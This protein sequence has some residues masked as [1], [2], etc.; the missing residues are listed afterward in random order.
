MAISKIDA[1]SSSVLQNIL[2]ESETFEEVCSKIG[3][4]QI[5][6]NLY[7]QIK[8]KCIQK[9]LTNIEVLDIHKTSKICLIC[10]KEKPL[11]EFYSKR[12]VCKECVRKIQQD[13]YAKRANQLNEYKQTLC[14]AKCGEKRFYLLDFHHINPN[15]K[16]FTISD[17]TNTKM[18][19]LQKELDKCIP[20]CAN[21][22]REFHW[23]NQHNNIS[24]EEY[25]GG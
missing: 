14:C 1:I 3:Y 25:L 10:N 18:E 15:E 21:C 5:G 11:T 8:T 4:K 20:L 6:K 16:D 19:T 13:K 2:N 12:A 7:T 23:L 9:N 24:L 22:H 17:A